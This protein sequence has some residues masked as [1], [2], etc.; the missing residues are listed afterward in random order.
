MDQK[1]QSPGMSACAHPR[2][3]GIGE[4]NHMAKAAIELEGMRELATAEDR[5]LTASRLR[6]IDGRTVR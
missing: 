6:S 2:A 5:Y 3:L 1:G 4:V